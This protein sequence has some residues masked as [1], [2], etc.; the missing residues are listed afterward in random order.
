MVDV[1]TPISRDGV[2]CATE[3]PVAPPPTPP[4]AVPAVPGADLFSLVSVTTEITVKTRTAMMADEERRGDVNEAKALWHD[5]SLIAL[6]VASHL[7]CSISVLRSP[8]EMVNLL[9]NSCVSLMCQPERASNADRTPTSIAISYPF[10]SDRVSLFRLFMSISMLRSSLSI[11]GS[12]MRAAEGAHSCFSV[13]TSSLSFWLS[14]STSRR[15]NDV[16]DLSV[17]PSLRARTDSSV[18][19]SDRAALNR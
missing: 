2:V 8:I 10:C 17:M 13:P 12:P 7:A 15:I 1:P 9:F 16:V 3:P 6:R 18:R 11:S 19:S 4:A 14:A 5:H